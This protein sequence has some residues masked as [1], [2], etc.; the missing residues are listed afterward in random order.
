MVKTTQKQEH[1]NKNLVK[2]PLKQLPTAIETTIR[3]NLTDLKTGCY[4][5]NTNIE[6]RFTVTNCFQSNRNT[7]FCYMVSILGVSKIKCI[8]MDVKMLWLML[9]LVLCAQINGFCNDSE[10]VF[11]AHPADL[12]VKEGEKA[13]FTCTLSESNPETDTITWRSSPPLP[14][15]AMAINFDRRTKHLTSRIGFANVNKHSN[16][17]HT[18]IANIVNLQNQHTTCISKEA[19]LNVMYFPR[20][21]ELYC[22]LSI[23]PN[24]QENGTIVMRCE[25]PQGNPAVN[26]AWYLDGTSIFQSSTYFLDN[27]TQ[28]VTRT[29]RC[30]S[31]IR[32]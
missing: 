22:S 12:T 10:S 15:N 24:L 1:N 28:Y 2:V 17:N 11:V 30:L 23:V 19:K 25:V 14:Y 26:M 6:R 29:P 27:N 21:K 3:L 5:K 9:L 7:C 16:S 32:L 13:M 20:K 4:H 18:C 8:R 31:T